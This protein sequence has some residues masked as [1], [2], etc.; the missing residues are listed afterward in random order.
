M[1]SNNKDDLVFLTANQREIWLEQE[2]FPDSP[3]Y[4][5]GGFVEIKA[6]VDCNVFYRA[7]N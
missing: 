2:L 7:V 1:T 5:I 6:A 3:I 4:N